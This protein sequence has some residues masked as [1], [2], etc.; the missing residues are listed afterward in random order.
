MD[1]YS[2]DAGDAL[3]G[4]SD[5][6]WV[7]NGKTFGARDYN[8]NGCAWATGW[9]F[10]VCSTSAINRNGNGIWNEVGASFDV[11]AS[12]MLVKLN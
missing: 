9:W 8:N 6:D 5:P 3:M 10:G 1:G 4:Q 11:Q 2:G 7:T 12:R